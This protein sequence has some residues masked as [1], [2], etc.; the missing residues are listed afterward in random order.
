[1]YVCMYVCV[2]IQEGGCVDVC[3]HLVSFWGSSLWCQSHTHTYTHTY[4][5]TDTSTLLHPH[6]HTLIDTRTHTYTHLVSF[7]FAAFCCLWVIQ[8][9]DHL[10][11]CACVCVCVCVCM[12]MCV[13]VCVCMCVCICI[14]VHSFVAP[15]LSRNSITCVLHEC[16]TRVT[17]MCYKCTAQVLRCHTR[18]TDRGYRGEVWQ[19]C[20]AEGKEMGKNKTN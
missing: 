20:K 6:K 8:E 4:T 2:W 10:Y 3:N 9:L 18:V 5:H 13:R 14:C 19:R 15:K 12:C 1:M 11:A 17:E 7:W 16:Y